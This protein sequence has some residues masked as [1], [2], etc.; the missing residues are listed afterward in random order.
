[1]TTII[2]RNQL[3]EVLTELEDK[4]SCTIGSV[5]GQTQITV[6]SELRH[7]YGDSIQKTSLKNV[8]FG[9]NYSKVINSRRQKEGK[10]PN[11]VPRPL[12]SGKVEKNGSIIVCKH[13]KL[14]L[15]FQEIRECDAVYVSSNGR[16]LTKHEI[17]KI[18]PKKDYLSGQGIKNPVK[19]RLMKLENIKSV[20]LNGGTY[21]IGG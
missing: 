6:P 16:I 3:I 20:T 15:K 2:P 10:L 7:I 18:T 9:A 1:M 13:G 17:R 19:Y 12:W 4:G 14:Y 21:F 8:L 11:F 5:M